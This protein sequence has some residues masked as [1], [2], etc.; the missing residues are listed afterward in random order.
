MHY[1]IV[2]V[3][4]V[5][6]SFIVPLSVEVLLLAPP[7]ILVDNLDVLVSVRPG[8]LVVEAERVHD[9]VQGAPG[10]AEAVAVRVR[11]SLQG[12]LLAGAL[13]TDVR[14]TS[15]KIPLVKYLRMTEQGI[16][17]DAG[18]PQTSWDSV[19]DLFWNVNIPIGTLRSKGKIKEKYPP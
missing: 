11:G 1:R 9:L 7:D 16:K 17:V 4:K 5:P 19:A 3:V 12:D 18:C 10:A 13:V 14:P 8:V 15:V 6:S 2:I